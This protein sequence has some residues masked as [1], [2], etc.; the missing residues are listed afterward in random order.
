MNDWFA[1][2]MQLKELTNVWILSKA[3]ELPTCRRNI[4]VHK[5]IA[6]DIYISRLCLAILYEDKITTNNINVNDR[7]KNY[8]ESKNYVNKNFSE[9]FF[10][11]HRTIS[12]RFE[13]QI[14][15]IVVNRDMDPK[16]KIV[17]L[18]TMY[19]ELMNLTRIELE[20]FEID[21]EILGNNHICKSHECSNQPNVITLMITPEYVED[22]R[23]I[24][25]I[26]D[27]LEKFVLPGKITL[28]V[29]YRNLCEYINKYE[30]E[31]SGAY[32]RYTK[33]KKFVKDIYF[34]R[35]DCV[36]FGRYYQELKPYIIRSKEEL[37]D[38]VYH[39][40]LSR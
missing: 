2:E 19:K 29:D 30:W 18:L 32:C 4:L 20:C 28:V 38:R 31:K 3:K 6:W 23:I 39:G 36:N 13:N 26:I 27:V 1:Q 10:A 22:V 25:G 37:R 8:L 16:S 17:S 9:F 34:Y 40:K 33:C 21:C 7:V 11:F 14:R 5:L 12:S 35:T 15:S 24:E